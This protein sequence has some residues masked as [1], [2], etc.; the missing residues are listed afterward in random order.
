MTTIDGWLQAGFCSTIWVVVSPVQ[1]FPTDHFASRVLQSSVLGL[2]L[3]STALLLQ[4]AWGL[5]ALEACARNSTGCHLPP[6]VLD[7][8]GVAV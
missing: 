7:P 2:T 3:D 4:P 8:T 6:C 5:E 1:S